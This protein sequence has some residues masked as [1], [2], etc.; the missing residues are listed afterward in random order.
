MVERPNRELIT[1]ARLRPISEILDALDS[2]YQM[3]WAARQAGVAGKEIPAGLDG[4]VLVERQHALNW[5]IR[6]GGAAWDD[7]DTP[8]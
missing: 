2:N 6:W 8:T 4:G 7:V 1:D 5:L 3:L